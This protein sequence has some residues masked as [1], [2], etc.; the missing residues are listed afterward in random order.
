MFPHRFIAA[1]FLSTAS[2]FSAF[3]ADGEIDTSFDV[4]TG[5]VGGATPYPY[6]TLVQPDGKIIVGGDFTSINGVTLNRI[7]RL[8]ADGSIDSSFNSGS[9]AGGT[10]AERIYRTAIQPDGKIIIAGTFTSFNGTSIN[11]I[12]RLNTDGSLDMTFNPGSGANNFVRAVLV[13]P[14]GKIV[15]G[16][17]F[18]SF[19]GTSI[20]R[21]AR[22]NA[23]G[24]LDG[25]FNVGTG[26]SSG[27]YSLALQQDNK[28]LIAGNFSSVAGVSSSRGVA[29]LNSDGTVDGSFSAVVSTGVRYIGIQ[30]DGKIIIAGPFTGVNGYV[31]G[32]IARLT[33][34]GAVD[35]DFVPM[36]LGWQSIFTAVLQGDGKIVIAGSLSGYG[37]ILRLNPDGSRDQNFDV[38]SGVDN[39]VFSL[40]QQEDGGIIAVGY[41]TYFNGTNVNRLVRIFST[42]DIDGDGTADHLDSDDD[43]DGYEDIGDNCRTI[44]NADQTDTDLDLIGDA[45]DIDDDNDSY[46]DVIDAFPIDAFEWIDTDADGTGNNADVDDD[47]DLLGDIQDNCPLHVNADQLNN[48]NDAEGDA[49]D[50]DDDN[51]GDND[52]ADNCP[53]II[54]AD[55]KDSDGDDIGDACDTTILPPTGYLDPGFNPLLNGFVMSVKVQADQKI[56]I[57]G[58]FNTVNGFTQNRLARLNADGTLDTGFNIGTAADNTVWD[59]AIQPDGK[60]LVVGNFTTINGVTKNRIVR[61]NVDGT[62]DNGFSASATGSVSAI[63]V[64]S[65]GKIIVGGSFTNFNGVTKNRIV[66]LNSDGSTDSSFNIG[67]GANA[68]VNRIIEQSDGKIL[69][70]GSF[71]SFNGVSKSRIVRLNMDGSVDSGFNLGAGPD[72]NVNEVI[73][74]ADGKI[75][76]GGDFLSYDGITASKIARLNQDGTLDS[77]FVIF[78]DLAVNAMTAQPDGKI[79]IVGNYIWIDGSTRY[80]IARLN[81]DGSIDSDFHAGAG[82]ANASVKTCAYQADGKIIIGGQFTSVNRTPRTYIARLVGLIDTDMDG[83]SDEYDADDDNDGILDINDAFPLDATESVDTDNDGTGNNADTD[84]DNDGA[85]DIH[86]QYP[87]SAS[88]VNSL[89]MRNSSTGAWQDFFLLNATVSSSASVALDNS[90]DTVYQG[91][92]DSGVLTRLTSTGEWF[93]NNTAVAMTTSTSWQYQGNGDFDNDGDDDVL[94]RNSGSG[95]WFVYYLQNGAVN[96][97][98]GVGIYANSSFVFQGA[99][100]MNGD[101]RDDVLFRSTST[102]QWYAYNFATNA[103]SGIGGM[104]LSNNWQFQA[105]MDFNNDGLKDILARQTNAGAANPGSWGVFRLNSS[106]N[107]ASIYALTSTYQ[108]LSL[109]GFSVAGDYDGNGTDDLLLRNTSSGAY[110]MFT[111]N[112]PAEANPGLQTMRGYPALYGSPWSVLK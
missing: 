18:T 104:W 38:G 17:D 43:E 11:R 102:G 33:L 23:N 76:I 57:G 45:C 107:I 7:A 54:N 21:I 110:Y 48:D 6:T 3:A 94:L 52:T 1:L 91:Q 66:R 51:D 74:L 105:L 31:M 16:G 9:G 41:F 30:P 64:Q 58:T 81:P 39:A 25:T 32:S 97:S 40:S 77:S 55:Q 92:L 10:T 99:G 2:C 27:V 112:A 56:L 49:C 89:L 109:I 50:I 73:Q 96:S 78:S 19:N 75:M 108:N 68:G 12:A 4:G 44:A 85:L 80:R 62:I 111:T 15:I 35:P 90:S 100:D 5:V 24:S 42:S 79:I 14:D 87:L 60:I 86:D 103:V 72:N 106:F 37:G 95:L 22:L 82:G 69:V 70:A 63:F 28:I 88:A 47:N 20:N 93:L 46:L 59:M 84:D 83:T 34:T 8:N 53:W 67:S 13:L 26:A 71:T 29:R 101:G 36:H 61:L 65:D 98:N